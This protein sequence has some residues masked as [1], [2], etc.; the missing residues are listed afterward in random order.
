MKKNKINY[1]F[2]LIELLAVIVILAIIALIAVPLVMKAIETS[3]KGAAKQTAQNLI[4][5][6]EKGYAYKLLSDELPIE[7][8]LTFSNDSINVDSGNIVL[9]YKGDSPSSGTI[10]IKSNSDIGISVYQNGYCSSK[11]L[12]EDTVNTIKTTKE[13]CSAVAEGFFPASESCFGF[14]ELTQTITSYS[15]DCPKDLIIPNQIKKIDVLNIGAGSFSGKN[16]TNVV[17][18]ENLKT[19]KEG[20]FMGNN[21]TTVNIPNSVTHI[22]F[23]SFSQSKI[24]H[25][26]LGSGVKTIDFSA[27]MQNELTKVIIPDNVETIGNGAFG[28]NKISSL[29][30]GTSL[31]FID[32]IAFV[33]NNL[34]TLYI[35]NN[36][37][38][39]GQSAFAS[40]L[41]T[42]VEVDNNI[43]NVEFDSPFGANGPNKDTIITPIFKR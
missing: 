41:L 38:K 6:S 24:K 23:L 37:V 27:F 33:S 16:L 17:F 22:G 18:P 29:K 7:T 36:V 14:D 1:G 8:V 34:E 39:I 21:L 20:A 2:T 40:N 32:T 5:A 9:D 28:N 4:E 13:E 43:N 26:N 15:N 10:A 31:T 42:L 25:L 11:K 12:Y 35:P 19:I 3:K 30:L